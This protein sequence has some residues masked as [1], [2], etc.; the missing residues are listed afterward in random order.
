MAKTKNID[1]REII[2]K[3]N[4]FTG[5]TAA[6]LYENTPMIRVFK[7]RYPR[8]KQSQQEGGEIVLLMD[9]VPP[10]VETADSNP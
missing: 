6:V 8:L 4:D 3:E 2:A 1:D 5:F 10:A 7:K 9:F